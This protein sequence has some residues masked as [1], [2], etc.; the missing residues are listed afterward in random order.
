MGDKVVELVPGPKDA[1][2]LAA[3]EEIRL[4]IN[5]G[6]IDDVV[7]EVGVIS[8]SL[9]NL[10][11]IIANASNGA[12]DPS[13]PVGRII[14]NLETVTKDL[15]QLTG[16]NKEKVGEVIDHLAEVTKTLDDLINSSGDTG[17]RS[18][19]GKAIDSVDHLNLAW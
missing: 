16:Q 11:K 6:S 7:G 10:A 3:G 2:Q 14:L 12:G 13:T 15:A 8:K 17:L 19:W 9:G 5:K 1:P 18:V 4:A